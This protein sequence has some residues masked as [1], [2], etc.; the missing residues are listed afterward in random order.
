MRLFWLTV[1]RETKGDRVW[2]CRVWSYSCDKRVQNIMA[3]VLQVSMTTTAKR[4][5]S[6]FRLAG[7]DSPRRTSTTWMRPSWM[8]RTPTRYGQVQNIL[9]T[10]MA[11]SIVLHLANQS[12]HL[13]QSSVPICHKVYTALTTMG[14]CH[15]GSCMGAAMLANCSGQSTNRS[16]IVF[17]PDPNDVR[18]PLCHLSFGWLDGASAL[19]QIQ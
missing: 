7:T 1:L 19:L 8:R 5:S 11:G 4:R 12:D 3:Y 18:A 15:F 17:P 9:E 6:G 14:G 16:R 13:T 10:R 2:V